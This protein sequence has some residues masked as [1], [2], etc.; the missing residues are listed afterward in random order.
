MNKKE[1]QEKIILAKKLIQIKNLIMVLVIATLA[2]CCFGALLSGHLLTVQQQNTSL[3]EDVVELNNQFK[4]LELLLNTDHEL[5]ST[6]EPLIQKET[7][8]A[9][10]FFVCVSIVCVL[11]QQTGGN[12][13]D[14]SSVSTVIQNLPEMDS[15]GNTPASAALVEPYD[16]FDLG[17]R[18]LSDEFAI[19]PSN[20]F[21]N[22]RP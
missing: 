18:G 20:H 6:Q 4:E 7:L 22:I 8:K 1:K 2:L 17:I 12:S 5:L 21:L 13:G 15:V 14:A 10:F 9:I 3:I 16:P 11:L 19:R